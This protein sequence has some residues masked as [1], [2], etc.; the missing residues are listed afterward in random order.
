M[1][2]R[3]NPRTIWSLLS[4][5]IVKKASIGVKIYSRYLIEGGLDPTWAEKLR[6]GLMEEMGWDG[7]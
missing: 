1:A 6:D 4:T 5:V 2:D 3:G 7:K